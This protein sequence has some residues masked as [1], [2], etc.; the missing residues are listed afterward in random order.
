MTRGEL[1]VREDDPFEYPGCELWRLRRE[2]GTIVR[3]LPESVRSVLY[4]VPKP[5]I[6]DL[7]PIVA[8]LWLRRLID[9]LLAEQSDAVTKIIDACGMRVV[10]TLHAATSPT[11]P[12]AGFIAALDVDPAAIT[13]AEAE[14]QQVVSVDTVRNALA[15]CAWA[16]KMASGDCESDIVA[17]R[18]STS[19]GSGRASTPTAGG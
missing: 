17:A 11:P 15:L 3:S 12:T 10:A 5:N 14:L 18:P 8:E 4:D 19:A 1:H 6:G 7:D 2:Q 16:D 9:E 13:K